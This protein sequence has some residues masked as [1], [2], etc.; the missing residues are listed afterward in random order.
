MDEGDTLAIAIDLDLEVAI[1]QAGG[2]DLLESYQ[3]GD[4]WGP[5]HSL[6][7]ATK[8]TDEELLSEI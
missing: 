4:G 6:E 3:D 2:K 8:S 7:E 5:R 1:V